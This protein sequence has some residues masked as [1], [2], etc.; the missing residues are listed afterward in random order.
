VPSRDGANIVSHAGADGRRVLDFAAPVLFQN[1][2]VGTVHLGLFQAPLT[3]VANLALWLLA[4]LTL[5][6]A[7]AVAIGTYVMVDRLTPPLRVLRNSLQELAKGHYDYRIASGRRDVFGD[8]YATFDST[9]AALQQR[10]EALL[11]SST[12]PPTEMKTQIT[13]T[14]EAAAS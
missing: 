9:A 11:V 13:A 5:V 7:A 10:H 14:N 8:I 4:L 1:K 3:A 6:T 2:E 12:K